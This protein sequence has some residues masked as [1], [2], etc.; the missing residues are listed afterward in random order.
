LAPDGD[1]SR[2][3]QWMQMGPAPSGLNVAIQAMPD[4]EE[5]I[6]EKRQAE[7]EA[8]MR[9]TLEGIKALAESPSAP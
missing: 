3:R 1:G 8:N 6:I 5:R 4:K 2:L 7:H 9:A